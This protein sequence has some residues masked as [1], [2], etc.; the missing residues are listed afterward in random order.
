MQGGP[1]APGA[2]RDAGVHAQRGRRVPRQQQLLAARSGRQ[3]A[4]EQQGRH[5]AGQQRGAGAGKGG[6][7]CARGTETQG[8]CVAVAEA[9]EAAVA[10]SS[11][12]CFLLLKRHLVPADHTAV[13]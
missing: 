13:L 12:R 9:A 8:A 4:H 10:G 6:A 3:G 1:E 7:A 5:S 11:S 2:L